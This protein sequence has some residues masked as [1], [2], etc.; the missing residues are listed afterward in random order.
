MDTTDETSEFNKVDFT[1]WVKQHRDNWSIIGCEW[2]LPILRYLSYGKKRYC[3]IQR[4]LDGLN[5]KTMTRILDELEI[6]NL[7]LRTE[8]YEPKHQVHYSLLPLSEE[9]LKLF[10]F[11]SELGKNYRI[12]QFGPKNNDPQEPSN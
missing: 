10:D 9:Y 1:L 12:A 11:S 6:A 7:V 2:V 4:D 8:V 5:Y 3:E